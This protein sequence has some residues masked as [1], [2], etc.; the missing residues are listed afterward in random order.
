M[1]CV[2]P[3]CLYV[4]VVYLLFEPLCYTSEVS[5]EAL[6]FLFRGGSEGA[7]RSGDMEEVRHIWWGKAMDGFENEQ[8]ELVV[9][10]CG[11]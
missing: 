7:G 6:I 2:E 8:K 1:H 11:D 10:P 9:H 3:S 5:S 4:S